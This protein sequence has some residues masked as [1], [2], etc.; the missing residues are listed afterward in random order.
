MSAQDSKKLNE[1]I[2]S[3]PTPAAVAAANASTYNDNPNKPFQ[4]YHQVKRES[5]HR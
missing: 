1:E 2:C 5:A 4:T 3:T